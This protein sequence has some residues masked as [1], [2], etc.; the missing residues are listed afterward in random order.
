MKYL[1]NGSFVTS[2]SIKTTQVFGIMLITNLK[3][4]IF[5]LAS[6]QLIRIS[7][8]CDFYTDSL[9]VNHNFHKSRFN[10]FFTLAPMVLLTVNHNFLKSRLKIF[11]YIGSHGVNH[12]FVQSRFLKNIFT[13]APMVLIRISLKVD[14]F[15][16]FTLALMVLIRIPLKLYFYTGS[17]GVITV[18]Q[19]S[20]KTIFFLHCLLWC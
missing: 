2:N 3:N 17:H 11:F 20:L 8:K 15:Y 5:T 1:W 7:L 19:N 13:L 9:G 12:N 16:I 6:M 18:N 10:F 14:F 4:V